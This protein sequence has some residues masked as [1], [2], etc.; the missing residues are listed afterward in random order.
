MIMQCGLIDMAEYLARGV[1]LNDYKYAIDSIA[2]VGPGGSYLVDDLTVNLLHSDEFFNSPYF[3]FSGG[4][5]KGAPGM[6]E[7]AHQ[8]AEDIVA[9]YS[10]KVPDKIQAAIKDFFKDKY[11]DPKVADL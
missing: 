3:D 10:P 11:R 4:N 6:Y 9:N 8:K 5:V 7:I 1:E 2:N